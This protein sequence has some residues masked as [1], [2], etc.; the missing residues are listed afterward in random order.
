[1]ALRIAAAQPN[2]EAETEF[3]KV[4]VPDYIELTE[5]DLKPSDTR[6]GEPVWRQ[7]VGN[8][9]SHQNQSTS[10]FAKGYAVRLPDGIR[11]TDAGVAYLAELGF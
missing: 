4:R 6:G 10:I 3:I 11:V 7:I 2:R 9:V 5:L 8:V 1:M